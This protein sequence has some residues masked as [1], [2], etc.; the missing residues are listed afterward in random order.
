MSLDSMS[1]SALMAS[2]FWGALAGGF[3]I[4]G[5]RQKTVIPFLVGVALTVVSYYFLNSALSMSLA[6]AVI[7]AGFFWLKKQGY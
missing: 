2:V 5:W 6:G 1:I 7:L 4:Y 3:L